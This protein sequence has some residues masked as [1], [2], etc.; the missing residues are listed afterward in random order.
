MGA[1]EIGQRT[2]KDRATISNF[3]RLLQLPEAIQRHVAERKLTAGHARC[4]ITIAE[5]EV[6]AKLS[7]KCI[8]GGWS[9]RRLE[10]AAKKIADRRK[11]PKLKDLD[12]LDMDPNV[13]AAVQ[14]MERVLGTK[15]RI[16]GKA[17]KRGK[18][19]I[20]YYSQDDLDRIYEAIVGQ[21]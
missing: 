19:E 9:V 7:E 11:A 2:G 6:Q 12:Q 21:N 8:D 4:L 1:E 20:E 16:V 13:R 18:I 5:P 17:K 15:V 3:M 10:E 14:E